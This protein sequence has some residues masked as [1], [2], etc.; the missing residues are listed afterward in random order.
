[1]SR[2]LKKLSLKNLRKRTKSNASAGSVNV[3][4]SNEVPPPLPTS[5]SVVSFGTEVPS[6]L[7]QGST[8]YSLSPGSYPYTP[9]GSTPNLP[10]Q[11]HPFPSSPPT[12]DTPSTRAP[13][14]IPPVPPLPAAVTNGNVV[15]QDDLS[16]D[17]QGAWASA[18]TDPK[19]SKA[20]KALQKLENGVA[21]AMAKETKSA[22]IITTIKTGLTAVGGMEV[23]EERLNT[24]TEGMPVLMNALDEVAKLHPFIGVAVMAFKAVWALEQKRRE[25]DQK[26]L[27]LHMEMK[28]MMAILTQLKNV[29]DVEEIAP[30]GSTI[31]GRMQELAKGTAN[32]IK[33]CA[34]ACDT[35]CKKKLVVK[36]LKGP[37][38]EGKLAKFA[39]TFTKRRADFEFALT[40]HTAVGVDTANRTINAVDKTTQEINDK[41][42]MMLKLFSQF[43]TPEQ[44]EMARLIEQ[45]GG[46]VVLNDDKALKE[47]ND[48]EN[49]T[50]S[51]PQGTTPGNKT[52]KPSSLEDLK[53]DLHLDPDVAMEQNM[54]KF[55]QKLDIQTRQITEEMERVVQRQGDRIISA[56]TAGPHD[57]IIDPNIHIIWKEMGWRGS[58]KA[59]H[60]VMALR[61]H[62]QEKEHKRRSAGETTDDQA[63]IAFDKA[64]EWTLQYISVVR[65]QPI[66]EAWDDDAS[67][68]VTVSETNAF[69]TARPLDWSLPQ[70]I[71]YWAIG[72]HQVLADYAKK[73]NDILAKMFA[74]L[75]KILP[76]NKSPAN[77]YLD[78]VYVR[79]YSLTASVNP[80]N[81]NDG[82]DKF[83]SYVQ[84]EEARIRANLEAV[85]YDIDA[86]DTLELVTGAGR[87]DRYV[88][89][90]LYLLLERHFEI[91]RVAQTHT[92]HADELWDAAD[93]V[94]WVFDAVNLR[95]ELL[96][97]IFKQQ[98]AR[99]GPTVQG[100]R[101]EYMNEP[102]GLWDARLVQQADFPEFPYDDSVE[103]QDV[104]VTKILNYPMDQELLDFDA[105]ASPT[106]PQPDSA[107]LSLKTLPG[108]E[109]I[110]GVWHGF[111]YWSSTDESPTAGMISM[112]FKPSSMEG[113]VQYFT[114]EG[115]AN[116][117]DF[118]IAGEY[119]AG[120]EPGTASITFKRTFAAR[121]SAQRFIGKWTAATETLTGTIGFD[122]EPE[123]QPGAFVFKRNVTPEHMCF[124][125]APVQLQTNKARALWA[126]AIDAVKFDIRRNRWAWSYFKERRDRR[127]RFMELYIRSGG[128]TTFGAPI[129]DEE[130]HELARIR[131]S[132]TT[133]D[134]RFYHSLAEQHIRATTKH[135][136][137]SCD[138]CGGNI[139]GA[140]ITCLIC[141][142]KDTINSVDF[143]STP[144]CIDNRIVR[145]DIQK[146]HLPHHD[147]LK[148]RRVV[149]TR[150]FGKIYR[151]AK[152]AIKQAR[153]FFKPPPAATAEA[154]SESE[155]DTD[156]EDGHATI[157]TAKRIPT[158]SAFAKRLSSVPTVSNSNHG[159]QAT[160][161]PT[162][163]APEPVIIYGPPCCACKK[164]VT[165]PCWYCVQC[166]EASFICWECDAKGEVS[167]GQHDYD[168]HDLVRVQELIEEKDLSVEERLGELEERF[169]KH[170]KAMDARLD[171]MEALLEQVLKKIGTV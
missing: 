7:L 74:I 17:L 12:P 3:H 50:G 65:L 126:F 16:K 57:K 48:W 136:D 88:L 14:G 83:A 113:E 121:F 24:F 39:G 138:H 101:Y 18:N 22:T 86:A 85:Q 70:W 129:T 61:D 94:E 42:D 66:S 144:G 91:F 100:I 33:A 127:L 63:G 95:V 36:V 59:R 37:I 1:M 69:T 21:G 119:R 125:P 99:C 35:Y 130:Y 55:S 40:I 13:N 120:D 34:N 142:M 30:D 118:K 154:D 75:P 150:Q 109:G 2:I 139:G 23:I 20:D 11:A 131:K 25:N 103:A 161:P 68:F 28:D 162:K 5:K 128:S 9:S 96:Q 166:A 159:A 104:D 170:E 46:Q 107:D 29:K 64:D 27:A 152:Q 54:T 137:I 73:I 76:V 45:R 84:P 56:V 133:A 116:K 47:L 98:K 141:Q 26:I 153:T 15:P 146:A 160:A 115:R 114:A 105:Y 71:A 156:D 62:F 19:A 134:S 143:C 79:V 163:K 155:V 93:T 147:L 6:S 60:F 124:S 51:G 145:D 87:I 92:L 10:S 108:F 38:W 149:H 117:M 89:P 49:K 80:C 148:V 41:M 112:D 123:N 132:M 140:R 111:F 58:V 81:I 158:I 164:P 135:F 122:D 97:S 82:H 110:L 4:P 169:S 157:V 168:A 8:P 53:D 43:V 167:F 78:S 90:V 165:Q 171:R 67:G 72:H 102:N 77:M 31:K 151:D 32:D 106:I 52:A 44:K